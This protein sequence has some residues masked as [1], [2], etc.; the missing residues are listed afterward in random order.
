ME[1][2]D[3]LD[4]LRA[5]APHAD[6]LLNAMLEADL[7]R[8][9]FPLAKRVRWV[10]SLSTGVENLLSEAIVRSPVPM[11]NAR[12][13]FR[14]PL[15]EF[16]IAACLFFAKDL[17]R[18]VRNQEAGL[19]AQFD[20]EEIHGR[21]MGIAGY[22]EIGR[23][24][25]EKAHALGMRIVALRR[26]PHL[27]KDDRLLEAVFPPERLRDMLAA[28]DYVVLAMPDTPATRGLI[29]AAE[30]RAMK[31]NAV[32]INVG[33]GTLIDE[34]ALTRALTE[35]WIRGAALDVFQ[36]E[37]LPSPHPYYDLQ[38]LLLSPH[39]ADHTA[40][41]LD[42]AMQRFVE[43]LNRFLRDEPLEAVVDKHAGY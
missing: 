10:H 23:A 39:A 38:N 18:L 8:A 12:G 1:V 2:T 9:I 3:R 25:A 17:R 6:V 24:T 31:P 7:L 15:A 34:S 5:A 13:V 28:S 26:R 33:R 35:K 19:W 36:Q 29:A 40:D 14:R 41:W 20:I 42:L 43:N 37:P 4:S 27:S 21:V 32:L 30:L 16:V 22:G 11:T